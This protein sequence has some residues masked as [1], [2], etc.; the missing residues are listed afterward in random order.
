MYFRIN[1][2]TQTNEGDAGTEAYN[3]AFDEYYDN[4]AAVN[5]RIFL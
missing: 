2:L 1:N 4:C 3:E 5:I